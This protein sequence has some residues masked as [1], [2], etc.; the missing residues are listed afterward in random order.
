MPWAGLEETRKPTLCDPISSSKPVNHIS[1][2]ARSASLGAP[3][4]LIP[5]QSSSLLLS[6]SFPRSPSGLNE[7]PCGCTEFNNAF[8]SGL[9][10]PHLSDT[11][12]VV[13]LYV[14]KRTLKVPTEMK[15]YTIYDGS[16]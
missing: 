10:S 16:L 4:S 6:L 13:G 1:H 9:A 7:L 3:V 15:L 14:G 8:A 12:C 5:D 11:I 2:C